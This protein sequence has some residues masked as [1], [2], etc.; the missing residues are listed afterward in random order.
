MT[1]LAANRFDD[2]KVGFGKV[3]DFLQIQPDQKQFA[4][5]LKLTR[6]EALKKQEQKTGF[7]DAQR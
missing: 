2:P 3:F 7:I 6:L 4:N 5:A 1:E